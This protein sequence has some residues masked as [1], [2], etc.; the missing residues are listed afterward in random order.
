MASGISKQT[1]AEL[2]GAL[3]SRYSDSS[4]RDKGRILDE[5]VAVSG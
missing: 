2:L 4:K 1:R 3:R 5:F